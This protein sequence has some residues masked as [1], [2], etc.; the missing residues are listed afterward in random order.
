MR[1][2]A[3]RGQDGP[4]ARLFFSLIDLYDLAVIELY[5]GGLRISLID[6]IVRDMH[7]VSDPNGSFMRSDR[8]ISPISIALKKFEI[9][10]IW[11]T[12]NN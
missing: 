1:R 11:V 7:R 6:R 5:T 12:T 10:P 2:V 4:A 8:Q 3:V 9:Y